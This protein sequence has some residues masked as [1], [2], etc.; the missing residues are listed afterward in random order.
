MYIFQY[1]ECANGFQVLNE[2]DPNYVVFLFRK[3]LV[4]SLGRF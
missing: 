4:I 2:T 1:L 3:K